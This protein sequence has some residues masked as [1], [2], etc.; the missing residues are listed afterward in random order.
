MLQ[1]WKE[2][3][4][5]KVAGGPTGS[6]PRLTRDQVYQFIQTMNIVHAVSSINQQGGQTAYQI[7][8]YHEATKTPQPQLVPIVGIMMVSPQHPSIDLYDF[9]IK[10]RNVGDATARD[11]T[12]EIEIPNAYA[13]SSYGSIAR[14][15]SHDRGNVAFYRFPTRHPFEKTPDFVLYPGQTSDYVLSIDFQ[16]LH[17]QYA[18]VNA[19]IRVV[20]YSGDAPPTITEIPIREYRNKDRLDQLGLSH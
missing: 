9:R 20:V 3:H 18:D 4:E 15:T 7:I 11:F 8:N 6:R 1:T 19:S 12:V 5:G 17:E 13:N 14:V 2:K 16:L 10:L